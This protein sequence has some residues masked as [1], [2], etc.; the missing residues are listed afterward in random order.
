MWRNHAEKKT[1]GCGGIL[2]VFGGIIPTGP[3]MP[4][5]AYLHGYKE[6]L[7]TLRCEVFLNQ[8][9]KEK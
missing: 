1:E 2:G 5:G 3:W 6:R 9:I 7:H 8:K 4:E